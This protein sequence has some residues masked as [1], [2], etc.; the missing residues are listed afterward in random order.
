MRTNLLKPLPLGIHVLLCAIYFSWVLP[1]NVYKYGWGHLLVMLLVAPIMLSITYLNRKW[2]KKMILR[3]F[4][5]RKLLPLMAYFLLLLFGIYQ[6]LY[7]YPNALTKRILKDPSSPDYL[8]YFIDLLTFYVTFAKWGLIIA[9][10]E[11]SCNVAKF[12]LLLLFSERDAWLMELRQDGYRIWVAHFLGNLC[13]S[14]LAVFKR[15]SKPIKRLSSFVAIWAY[16]VRVM[17]RKDNLF[18][19]IEEELRCLRHL[20]ILYKDRPID[21][22]ENVKGTAHLIL[23]MLLLSLYKNMVKHGDFSKDAPQAIFKVESDER[24]LQVQCINPVAE[25]NAWR[26][27]DGGTGLNQLAAILKVEY[28]ASFSI[29]SQ[30][31]DGIF[32]LTLEYLFRNDEQI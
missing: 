29:A 17:S 13:Q 25:D 14:L 12:L 24:R 30:L 32:Y 27:E 1:V 5:I 19:P 26:F 11:V 7:R 21:I 8:L 6:L 15:K 31:D 16:G 9:M 28:G 10:L 4:S 23:P 22:S 20:A 3:R 18:V 2:L